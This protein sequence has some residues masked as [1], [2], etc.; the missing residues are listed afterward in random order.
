[1]NARAVAW[2]S[3]PALLVGTECA[4]AT[5]TPL[6]RMLAF[7]AATLLAMKVVV[8]VAARH[9]GVRVP[10]A[11]LGWFVLWFGMHPRTFVRRRPPGVEKARRWARVGAANVVVG[12]G[13]AAVAVTACSGWFVQ[14][15]LLVAFSMV[16]HFGL[17]ALLAA[18]LRLRGFAVPLLFD[19]PWRSATAAEFWRDRWNHGFTEMTALVVHRP[20]A[21]RWGRPRGLLA[22][23]VFSGVLHDV[24]LSLPVR[25]GWGLPTLYFVLQG[26]VVLWQG[27]RRSRVVTF[28]AVVLPAPLLFHPWFLA[29]VLGG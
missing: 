1:M 17:F 4:V 11:N 6:V 18:W 28:A 10:I 12:A 29:G 9:D 24:A 2:L 16:V 27:E 19:A 26:L 13:L 14:V 25:G 20:L 22:S 8:L 7:V 23:F 21:R 3:L 15:L 5:A